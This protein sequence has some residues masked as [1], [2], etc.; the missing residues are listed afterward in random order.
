[1]T[2]NAV[3]VP[4]ENVYYYE[5][6][7]GD[8][9]LL[10][11]IPAAVLTRL[12][13]EGACD[14]QALTDYPDGIDLPCT[15]HDFQEFEEKYRYRPKHNPEALGRAFYAKWTDTKDWQIGTH[16]GFIP[17]SVLEDRIPQ[18]I[19][20]ATEESAPE[21]EISLESSTTLQRRS[22]QAEMS[23][24]QSR[25]KHKLEN[26]HFEV[27]DHDRSIEEQRF[28]KIQMQ[29]GA[30]LDELFTPTNRKSKGE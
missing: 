15:E 11:F 29:R 13:D 5:V 26:L 27:V 16:A 24:D 7:R 25:L 28:H 8:F 19:D 12:V 4:A 1:M 3:E 30:T 22:Y 9:R 18:V 23:K 14:R 17:A 10:Y 2:E 20:I 6:S 21:E